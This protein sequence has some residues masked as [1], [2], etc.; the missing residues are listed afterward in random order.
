MT[1]ID[2]RLYVLVDRELNSSNRGV[3]GSHA[4]A[5]YLLRTRNPYGW[6][7]GTIV[8]LRVKAEELN[9]WRESF[10]SL[11]ITCIAFHEPDLGNQLTSIAA[12]VPCQYWGRFDGI[13]LS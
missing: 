8:M 3:Q 2:I 10:R 13:P 6:D 4:V 9:A 5:E 1:K 7:N 12:V 11:A